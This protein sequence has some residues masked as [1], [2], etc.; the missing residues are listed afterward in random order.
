MSLNSSRD[1]VD[2]LSRMRFENCFNP[3]SEVCPE[4][5][6]PEASS[7]RQ[8]NLLNTLEAALATRPSSMWIARD[9]GYRGGRR[10][11]LALTDE[12]HLSAHQKLLATKPLRRATRG[13][14]QSENT[15][16]SIWDVLNRL[17][18]PVFLWNVFPLHPHIQGQPQSNRS[19]TRS[20]ALD[21][22]IFLDWLLTKL[23][24]RKVLA[25]GRDAQSAL[26]SLG[27]ESVPVRHPSYGGKSDFLET[28][29][30][31]YG[32]KSPSCKQMVLL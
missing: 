20:E 10:T 25:I 21:C 31:E 28:M 12:C 22:R 1:F 11:G 8:Q 7:I 17:E 2:A 15:A 5:D 4:F 19:H 24:P 23:S 6:L 3:Y 32:L 14:L 26:A 29:N 27:V 18:Q 9:L 13:P 30:S 16:G